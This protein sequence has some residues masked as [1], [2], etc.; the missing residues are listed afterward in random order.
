[1][2]R[3]SPGRAFAATWRDLAGDVVAT[4]S[5]HTM[6]LW[7][8]LPWRIRFYRDGWEG[9]IPCRECPGCL[10]LERLRLAE[11]LHAK[12]VTGSASGAGSETPAPQN[13]ARAA[14]RG[15][16]RLFI[17]RI[18]APLKRHAAIAHALHRR[19]GLQLEPGFWRLGATSFALISRDAP[20]LSRVLRTLGVRF[21]LES[22]KLGRGRRAFRPLTAG[23][24]VSR[25]VYGENVNRFYS[26]GLPKADKQQWEVKKLAQ[27]RSYDPARAPRAWSGSKLV[28][29][30][31]D[32]WRLSRTDRRALRC[33]LARQADPEGVSKVMGL[34]AD[35]IRKASRGFT[36]SA[37]AKPAL[38]REQVVRSYE[39][40]RARSKA[41]TN[42]TAS[43]LN[44]P[45]LS[46]AGGYTTSEHSQGELMPRA[47][48]RER[49]REWDDAR[50]RRAVAESMAIIERMRRRSGGGTS[51][52]P[53]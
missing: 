21:R 20:F 10:E 51:S 37:P 7:P 32:V 1:M 52:E 47:L 29:V 18:Y 22:L 17:V 49:R 26:R 8:R 53:E 23:L 35:T 46:E 45:P 36:V 5:A 12:L 25:N 33:Q 42:V 34:I 50:K 30:P 11:R 44:I 39:R 27:Y 2:V 6:C 31:P 41:R 28:L 40:M 14:A 19:R 13:T 43:D 15:N 16:P 4:T 9:V 48:E 3:E 38:T 24:L